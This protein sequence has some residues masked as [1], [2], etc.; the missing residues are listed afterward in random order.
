MTA[1]EL[2]RSAGPA[3]GALARPWLWVLLGIFV[4]A[5]VVILTGPAPAI[6]SWVT[7]AACFAVFATLSWQLANSRSGSPRARRFWRAA[8]VSGVIF[9]AGAVLRAV[10]VAVDPGIHSTAWTAPTA[11]VTIGSAWLLAFI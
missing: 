6:T 3:G 11:L 10:D 1:A 7:Q 4:T 5:T 2:G 8:A 9:V